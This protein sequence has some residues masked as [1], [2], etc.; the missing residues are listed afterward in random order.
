MPKD[1][2]NGIATNLG[3]EVKFWH[4]ADALRNNMVT[5]YCRGCLP[6]CN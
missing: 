3:F 6:Q 2:N 5:D 1:M 4:T